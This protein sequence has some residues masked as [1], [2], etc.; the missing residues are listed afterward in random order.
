MKSSI[1]FS[2]TTIWVFGDWPT[3]KHIYRPKQAENGSGSSICVPG[4][5]F[6]VNNVYKCSQKKTE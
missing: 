4:L 3:L 6:D 2:P 1:N 5:K